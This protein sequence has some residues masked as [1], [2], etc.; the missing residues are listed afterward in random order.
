[1]LKLSKKNKKKKFK[2]IPY[3]N[4]SK[5]KY[6]K[7][8][9]SDIIWEFANDYIML[10]DDLKHKRNLLKLVCTAWNIGNLPQEL[11]KEALD[12]YMESL[13]SRNPEVDEIDILVGLREDM[14]KLIQKKDKNFAFINTKI[15]DAEIYEENKEFKV[16]VASVSFLK[17]HA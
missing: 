17:K 2:S 12:Q 4:I 7:M 6:S 16:K 14:E 9:M 3:I 10:G 1:V 11:R 15:I 5:I 13:K 8:K